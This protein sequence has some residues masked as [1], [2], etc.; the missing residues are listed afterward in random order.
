MNTQKF[1]ATDVSINP[2]A[3]RKAPTTATFLYPNLRSTGP[4]KNDNSI[5]KPWFRVMMSV[6]CDAERPVSAKASWN[7]SPKPAISGRTTTWKI[8]KK[9]I[10]KAV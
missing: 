5:P 9:T 6:P 7:T 1:D 10:D 3:I 2:D 4:P 8:T